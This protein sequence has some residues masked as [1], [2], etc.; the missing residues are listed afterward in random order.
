VSALYAVSE[1]V[2]IKKNKHREN[3][4]EIVRRRE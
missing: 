1:A 2:N 3:G 4:E